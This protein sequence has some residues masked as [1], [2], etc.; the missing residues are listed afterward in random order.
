MFIVR[1]Q[2]STNTIFVDLAKLI[3]INNYKMIY[4]NLIPVTLEIQD[5]YL[6]T[7]VKPA[8]APLSHPRVDPKETTPI[9]S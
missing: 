7:S 8:G 6:E 9:C 4:S 1:T 2:N 3:T 5:L